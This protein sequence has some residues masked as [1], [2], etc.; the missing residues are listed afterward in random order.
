[1]ASLSGR[2]QPCLKDEPTE[3]QE[4]KKLGIKSLS[5]QCQQADSEFKPGSVTIWNS[6]SVEHTVLSL[7]LLMSLAN[8]VRYDSITPGTKILNHPPTHPPS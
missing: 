2:C 7:G 1:M 8:C 5:S 6:Y 4:V 3:A